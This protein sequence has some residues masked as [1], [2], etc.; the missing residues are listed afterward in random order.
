MDE[1]C[2]IERI[3]GQTVTIDDGS[4]DFW[5]SSTYDKDHSEARSRRSASLS[6]ITMNPSSDHQSSSSSKTSPPEF[7]NQGL[8]VWNQIRQQWGGNKRHESQTVVREPRISSDATYE[9]LLGNTKPFP[10][11]I[12]LR[13]MI[14]FLVDIWEQ[15]GLYD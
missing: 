11:P 10:Q 7:V 4:S 15:E 9:D 5:S 1:G 14:N 3:E 8:I 12:P 2:K 6:G 13:E